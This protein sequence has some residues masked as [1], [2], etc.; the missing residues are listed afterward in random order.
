[1][2]GYHGSTGTPHVVNV[3]L[4]RSLGAYLLRTQELGA[5]EGTAGTLMLNP[6]LQ[7]VLEALHHVLAGGE[8]AVRIIRGGNP[9]LVEELDRRAARA[10]Q[11]A[12]ALHAMTG[13]PLDATV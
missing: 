8:V 10:L 5:V 6:V 1:V 4:T 9:D 12:H 2:D 7:P 11:D 3:T 13:L